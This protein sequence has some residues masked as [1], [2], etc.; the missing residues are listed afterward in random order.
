MIRR[1]ARGDANRGKTRTVP[2]ETLRPCSAPT[3]S[4]DCSNESWPDS[5]ARRGHDDS[6]DPPSGAMATPATAATH[7]GDL[8]TPFE[9]SPTARV[10]DTLERMMTQALNNP[11]AST[12]PDRRGSRR[13]RAAVRECHEVRT[14]PR[15]DRTTPRPDRGNVVSPTARARVDTADRRQLHLRAA[16]RESPFAR[17]RPRR[18]VNDPDARSSPIAFSSFVRVIRC[19]SFHLSVQRSA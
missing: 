9:T 13:G 1:A 6:N 7:A 14:G 11:A 15:P 8:R 18:D 10:I 5:T 2:P 17:I 12:V 19:S 16:V 3:L 4:P